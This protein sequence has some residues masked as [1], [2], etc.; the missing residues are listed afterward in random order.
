[1]KR[2]AMQRL[3][4]WK[5]AGPQRLPLLIRGAR[6]VGKTW[7]MREFGR[8][9]FSSVA[10]INFDNNPRMRAL[11]E[12]GFEIPRLLAGLQLEART[13]ITP[14]TLLIFDEVQEVPQALASLKYFRENAPAQPVLASGSMLGIALHEGTSFP[15][16]KVDFLD[17]RPMDFRETLDALG[18]TELAGLLRATPPDWSLVK[19]FSGRLVERLRQYL[20]LGGMP[21]VVATFAAGRTDG[22]SAAGA[23]AGAGGAEAAKSAGGDYDAARAVQ[24]RILDAYEQD[25]SKHAPNAMVPRIRH[26]WRSVPEQ[27]ARENRRF[28]YRSFRGRILLFWHF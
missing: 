19:A 10:Y 1:M 3:A 21:E 12:G 2:T 28:I 14:E 26:L 9:N 25:F 8:E 7:L 20:W 22:M 15:V 16:G 23:V 17:L 13:T 27:L 18:E 11:F 6:Q 4:A 24:L 5:N